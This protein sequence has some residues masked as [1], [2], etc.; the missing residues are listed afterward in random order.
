[1]VCVSSFSSQLKIVICIPSA[2][3]E[4]E[5]NCRSFRVS[6][7]QWS[8]PANPPKSVEFREKLNFGDIISQN[9]LLSQ[10]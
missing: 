6:Q 5:G 7:L 2:D 3:A 9:E 8:F 1:M 10:C 4:E